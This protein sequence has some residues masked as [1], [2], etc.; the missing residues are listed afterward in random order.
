VDEITHPE[1]RLS[2]RSALKR[3]GA[4]AAIAW[5]APVM[6]SVG[7]RAN[8]GSGAPCGTPAICGGGSPTLCAPGD[9]PQCVQGARD[10]V[11]VDCHFPN[12][13]CFNC[14]TNEEC[15]GVLGVPGSVCSDVNCCEGISTPGGR[16]CSFPC[17]FNGA[18]A[19]A[20]SYN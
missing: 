2:R 14:T 8:A 16:A 12:G 10:G 15:E 20:G 9:D 11:C 18:G 5:S 13:A 3:I 4:G 1:N 19:A 6:L 17:G 7:A